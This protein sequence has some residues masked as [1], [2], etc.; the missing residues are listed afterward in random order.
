M[1]KKPQPQ[2]IKLPNGQ[3]SVIKKDG[4]RRKPYTVRFTEGKTLSGR[5]IFKYIGWYAT[6]D[7]ANKARLLYT[8]RPDLF[9]DKERSDVTL[10]DVY[11]SWSKT[12]YPKKKSQSTV[13]T[14]SSAWK[15]LQPLAHVHMQNLRKAQLQNLIDD[16]ADHGKSDYLIGL[17]MKRK[18]LSDAQKKKLVA[19]VEEEGLSFSS[20]NKIKQLSSLLFDAAMQDDVVDKNYAKFILL[21]ANEKSPRQIWDDLER[22]KLEKAARA[23]DRIAQYIMVMCYMGWRINEFLSLTTFAYNTKEKAFIGGEKTEA[24]IDRL[25]PV[26][27]KIQPYVNAALKR[28]GEAVFCREDGGKFTAK[29]FREQYFYPTLERLGLRRLVPH[30]TRYV[31][32]Y[33]MEQAGVPQLRRQALAGHTDI[34][35]TKHYTPTDISMLRDAINSLK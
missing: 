26:H 33:L 2:K 18:G 15:K 19:G 34:Q 35:M 4:V 12:A 1:P 14:W 31:F 8:L 24:G 13:D 22:S 9:A 30:T 20:L 10:Q 16:Y 6:E 7:E 29:N 5:Q 25:V 3:G 28:K 21:P 27:K 17:I 23:G 11:D 32:H